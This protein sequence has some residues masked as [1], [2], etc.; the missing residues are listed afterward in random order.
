M[1]TSS[2][3]LSGD[4][5]IGWYI[6]EQVMTREERKAAREKQLADKEAYVAAHGSI[7]IYDAE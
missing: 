3:G 5:L 6:L 2:Y 7:N 4:R 1:P